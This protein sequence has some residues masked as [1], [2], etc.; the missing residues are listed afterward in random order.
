MS[1]NYTGVKVL[2]TGKENI[3][4]IYKDGSIDLDV[5][6]GRLRLS[7]HQNM[8]LVIKDEVPKDQGGTGS[9]LCWIKG[10]RAEKIKTDKNT[11]MSSI[12][13]RN[14]EQEFAFEAL[15]NNDVSV[16]TMAGIA[17][18]GKAQPLDAKILT[19]RGWVYM[20]DLSQGDTVF[21]SRG[22]VSKIL[23]IH[24]QGMKDIY[25]VHFSDGSSTECCMDHLWY[26][27]TQRDR[28]YKQSG[29]IKSLIEINNSL[30][31]G[32]NK[33]NHSIPM[34]KNISFDKRNVK[35]DPYLMGA[36]LGDGSISIGQ[37]SISSGDTE[38]IE[39]INKILLQY[40][41]RLNQRDR[42]DYN[43]IHIIKPKWNEGG[44]FITNC[45]KFYGLWGTKSHTKFIPDSYKFST[46]E[47]RISLLQGLL[48][49][50]GTIGKQGSV[51]YC[52]T[53]RE[54][55]EGVLFLVQS[56]GG[57]A[58]I[59]KKQTSYTYKKVKKKGKPSYVVQINLPNNIHP[60]RLT[61]K[62]NRVIPKTKYYPIRRYIDKIEFVARKPAQCI[63]IDDLSHL[64]VTDDFIVTHN[65]ILVLSAALQGIE[66]GRYERIILTRNMVQ[67]GKN[68]LGYLPGSIDDKV[69]PFN[70]GYMCN[71]ERLLNGK[72]SVTDLLEQMPIDFLPLQVIRGASWP[73]ALVVLD[74]AQNCTPHEVLSFG[75]RVGENS[76]VVLLGDLQQRDTSMSR[77]GTGLFRFINSPLS[78]E[79][80]LVAH[81]ELIKSER[82][83][84]ATLFSKV[85]SDV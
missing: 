52:S 39:E 67:V 79:S 24:P 1:E 23:S 40:K 78:K 14:K 4:S 81:I 35:I 12:C 26:T 5:F 83:E 68:H 20:G 31:V 62:Q 45:L 73:N 29:N 59:A 57:K 49:T 13:P 50:D 18:V 70:Q 85:F 16:V 53:S 76:K 32:C 3:D 30:R 22:I 21:T 72:G 80:P 34:V 69:M 19:P 15:L 44:N 36:L 77:E 8:F 38:I 42:Y 61:R 58:K 82:G 2:H 25:K 7:K 47:N 60:F 41:M 33:R 51:S 6:D 65:T 28:D 9:V 56:L 74:E 71:I 48:D 17:G 27:E 55:A 84:I 63:L 11:S 66:K 43:I 37:P 64:Y 10:M 46:E 54:L 75:T